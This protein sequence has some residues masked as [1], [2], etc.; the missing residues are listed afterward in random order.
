M[1]LLCIAV[2]YHIELHAVGLGQRVQVDVV[3]LEEVVRFEWPKSRHDD[4]RV[5]AAKST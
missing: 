2:L 4:E 1:W 3:E 5:T